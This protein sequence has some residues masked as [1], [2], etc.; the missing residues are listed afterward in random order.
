[1]YFN[2]Q[3]FYSVAYDLCITSSCFDDECDDC[4]VRNELASCRK[5]RKVLEEKLVGSEENA[6][7]EKKFRLV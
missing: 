5:E 4:K 1:M 6:K 2:S 3:F 7:L